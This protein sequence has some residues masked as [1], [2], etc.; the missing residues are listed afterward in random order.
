MQELLKKLKKGVPKFDIF[1]IYCIFMTYMGSAIL[2][3]LIVVSIATLLLILS[4]YAYLLPCICITVYV[5][6]VR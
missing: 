2:R 4:L 1:L 5:G 3:L 6:A